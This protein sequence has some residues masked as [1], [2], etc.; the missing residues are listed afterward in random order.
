[1][2]VLL[3]TTF[4]SVKCQGDLMLPLKN[5]NVAHVYRGV[6]QIDCQDGEGIYSIDYGRV[7]MV[8]KNKV[9]NL[10]EVYIRHKNCI[11]SY[12]N[13]RDLLVEEGDMV[14]FKQIIGS[15]AENF[16]NQLLNHTGGGES[17]LDYLV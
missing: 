3:G 16:D 8:C 1:M 17:T 15:A 4:F 14:F 6:A 12:S 11:T 9:T 5:G 2:A 13:L 10:A 7:I